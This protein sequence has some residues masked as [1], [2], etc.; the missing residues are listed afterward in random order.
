VLEDGAVLDRDRDRV[1]V[2]GAHIAEALDRL[3]AAGLVHGAIHAG[4]VH[5]DPMS[6]AALL[7]D[8]VGG[9]I[10]RRSEEEFL[11]W[12]ERTMMSPAL[13]RP[14]VGAPSPASSGDVP[15]MAP[16]PRIPEDPYSIASA[17]TDV[18]AFVHL[19]AH[20]AIGKRAEALLASATA[21][22]LGDRGRRAY[23]AALVAASPEWLAP[24]LQA[25]LTG[26]AEV[27]GT[28]TSHLAVL[29]ERG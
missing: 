2:L 28:A 17:T 3:H 1:L 11:V 22:S 5:V 12:A 10:R 29:G 26:R 20:A 8:V 23:C 15:R 4:H 6:G 21:A 25:R 9:F 27:A 24:W 18:R 14:D 7:A 13:E 19:L 16:A